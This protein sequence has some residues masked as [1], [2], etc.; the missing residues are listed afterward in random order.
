MLCVT[1]MLQQYITS[2]HLGSMLMLTAFDEDAVMMMMMPIIKLKSC[3]RDKAGR[4]LRGENT[5]GPGYRPGHQASRQDGGGRAFVRA[6]VRPAGSGGG[7][8]YDGDFIHNVIGSTALNSYKVCLV[9][10]FAY[11]YSSPKGNMWRS[12][13]K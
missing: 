10:V 9:F 6:D 7:Q 5:V 4:R 8:R 2:M 11:E 13:V 1:T 12:R 3:F